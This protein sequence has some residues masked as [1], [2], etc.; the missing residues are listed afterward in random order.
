MAISVGLSI[1][2]NTIDNDV[3]AFI[4]N[5]DSGVTATTGDIE[6]LATESSRISTVT[7]A[8]SVSLAIGGTG[9]AISGA[10]AA[11]INV[12]LNTTNA[13]V[14]NSTLTS[15]QSDVL[16]EATDTSAIEAVVA[17]AS[18]AVAGGGVAVG[19]SIGGAFATNLIGW[20]LLGNGS[21]ARCRPM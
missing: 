17:A 15:N 9:V 7:T 14:S 8:A 11:A 18:A 21:P 20:D 1:A 16:I 13:Y 10:G 12:I 2:I 4:S 19:V 5:A 3:A 6:V